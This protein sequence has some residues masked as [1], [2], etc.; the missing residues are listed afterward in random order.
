LHVKLVDLLAALIVDDIDL[1]THRG[2][3]EVLAHPLLCDAVDAVDDLSLVQLEAVG[4][5]QS[6]T[7]LVRDLHWELGVRRLSKD[8][9]AF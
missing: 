8:I 4:V 7:L 6:A 5:A 9:R 3:Q 1:A 2:D